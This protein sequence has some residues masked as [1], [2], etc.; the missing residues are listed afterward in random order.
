MFK[1]EE[2]TCFYQGIGCSSLGNKTALPEPHYITILLPDTKMDTCRDKTSIC[3]SLWQNHPPETSFYKQIQTF[4]I[5]CT[6]GK[7]PMFPFMPISLCLKKGL[8]E[9]FCLKAVSCVIHHP[10]SS[11]VWEDTGLV[12]LWL[13]IAEIH[14]AMVSEWWEKE[15]SSEQNQELLEKLTKWSLTYEIFWLL[16]FA[17]V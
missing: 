16:S 13:P 8:S 3:L 5:F 14:P 12:E 9:D 1:K 10:C 2:F 7:L 17:C 15:W 4:R 6:R 11:W